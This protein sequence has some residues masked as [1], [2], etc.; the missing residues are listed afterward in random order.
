MDGPADHW[1][2]D[3]YVEFLLPAMDGR[4]SKL[5]NQ[6]T[7]FPPFFSR[8]PVGPVRGLTIHMVRVS[9]PNSRLTGEVR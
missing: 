2:I 4:G 5:N 6:F 9:L 3:L 7:R 8:G 1:A